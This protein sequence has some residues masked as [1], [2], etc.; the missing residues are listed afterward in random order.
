M[1]GD[2]DRRGG[3]MRRTSARPWW[4]EWID[5]SRRPGW[6]SKSSSFFRAARGSF[7]FIAPLS[8][9]TPSMNPWMK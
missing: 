5:G 4:K 7:K 2:N 3:E 6:G 8:S 1:T 9:S